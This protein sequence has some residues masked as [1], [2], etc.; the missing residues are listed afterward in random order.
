MGRGAGVIGLAGRVE[1]AALAAVLDGADPATGER[2]SPTHGRVTVVGLDLT[3]AAPKQVS[4]LFGLGSPRTA[5]ETTTS[6]EAAVA[7][8]VGYL[9]RRAAWVRRERQGERWALP[10][11]GVLAGAFLHH[12]SRLADPHVHSHVLVANLAQGADGRW[13]ALDTRSLYAHAAAA[14]WLYGAHLR[15]EL[16]SRLGVEF[17]ADAE[18]RPVI[19][20]MEPRLSRAFSQRR[21]QVESQLSAWGATGESA[22]WAAALATR[23]EKDLARSPLELRQW[24]RERASGMGMG[25]EGADR[26][27]GRAARAEPGL[28]DLEQL[29]STLFGPGG[30]LSGA[31]SFSRPE[32]LRA[33]CGALASGAEVTAVEDLADGLLRSDLVV[34]RGEPG[35]PGPA[36]APGLAPSG[37]EWRLSGGPR[38]RAGPGRWA[39]SARHRAEEATL[40]RAVGARPAGPGSGH[41]QAVQRALARRPGLSPSEQAAVQDLAATSPGVVVLDGP[42][43]SLH[44]VLD[45][46]REA[47]EA[48][49][50]RILGTAPSR[51]HAAQLASLTGIP[52]FGALGL[53]GEGALG[54]FEEGAVFGKGVGA[55]GAQGHAQA[56]IVVTGAEAL[57]HRHLDLLLDATEGATLVLAGRLGGAPWHEEPIVARLA[58]RHVAISLGPA[59]GP[60]TVPPETGPPERTMPRE[61]GPPERGAHAVG[62]AVAVG[63]GE[64]GTVTFSPSAGSA[65]ARVVEEWLAERTDAGR[66]GAVMVAERGEV[67]RLNGLA[68]AHLLRLGQL[69]DTVVTAPQPLARGEQLVARWG[70]ARSGLS[71]GQTVTVESLD[72]TGRR[73]VVRGDDGQR[74]VPLREVQRGQLAYGYALS[75]ADAARVGPVRLLVLGTAEGVPIPAHG[76]QAASARELQYHVVAGAELFRSADRAVERDQVLGAAAEVA[77][78]AGVVA[79]IGQPPDGL[80][81]RAVWRRTAATIE[82]YR[83]RFGQELSGGGDQ[84]DLRRTVD[85][86]EAL[87]A[88]RATRHR[89]G[90]DQVREPSLSR[91]REGI[92]LSR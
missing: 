53:F 87:A 36:L 34:A 83:V 81:A 33:L 71:A 77:T 38:G 12:T 17:V 80:A 3:F 91:A 86:A 18:G 51:A 9:E 52:C 24:W 79:L 88:V 64:A 29:A 90:L 22:S 58:H 19:A 55:R 10:T 50:R 57:D 11:E 41:P 6:H 92:G 63:L 56:V 70:S 54:L 75:P 27:V 20:E 61:I 44:D 78:P 47:W 30:A 32:L 40:A 85:R 35:G 62:D 2:L 25:A 7:A 5:R 76:T 49:G 37:Q 23:P 89:L 45:A 46:A 39:S 1:G 31:S 26:F 21:R 59:T 13:S 65:R 28:P 73:L 14:G 8:S 15:A 84:D 74:L 72:T 43:A 66:A 4:L 60:T 16:S 68:R 82:S 48:A 67:G 69:G 42:I